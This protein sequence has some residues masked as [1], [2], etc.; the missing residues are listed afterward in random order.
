M[1]PEVPKPDLAKHRQSKIGKKTKAD[2][3]RKNA[4]KLFHSGVSHRKF[5]Y[6]VLNTEATGSET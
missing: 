6:T 5:G 4:I 2:E 3:E 1:E